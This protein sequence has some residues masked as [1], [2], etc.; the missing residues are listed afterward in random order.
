M[1]QDNI[2]PQD[3]TLKKEPVCATQAPP[4]FIALDFETA[5]YG[6]DS[7]CALSIVAV[8]G[9]TV[10]QH[11]TRLI[12][13]PRRNIVFSYLHGITWSQVADQPTFQE[14]WPELSP[15]FDGVDFVAAHNAGFDRGVLCACCQEGGFELPG[16]EFLCTVKLAR[17]VWNIRPT[18]LPDVCRR[19]SIPLK[20]HDAASDAMACAQI[21]VEAVKTGI[22]LRKCYKSGHDG[23]RKLG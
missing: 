11:V 22:D 20:H 8:H 12:R 18:K 15:L 17:R 23:S 3:R 16:I 7:A 6:Q 2:T 13:P 14:L 1:R 9:T 5:D 10:V 21:V 19:L 4:H